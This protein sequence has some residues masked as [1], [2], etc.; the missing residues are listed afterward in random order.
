MIRWQ[1]NPLTRMAEQAGRIGPASSAERIAPV[2]STAE[3]VQ[4]REAINAM[5]DRMADSLER[6]H[7][8]ASTAAHELRTP[9]AQ[10]RTTIEVALRRD[11][12][13]DE[14]R[15]ALTEILTDVERLQ[16]LIHGLLQLARGAEHAPV[17][18]GRPVPLAALIRDAAREHQGVI[19]ANGPVRDDLAVV[20][21]ESLLLAALGNVLENAAHHA[22][23]GPAFLRVENAGTSVR[24][25]VAD[26]GPGVPETERERI[27]QPLTRLA[28]PR[29][30][31]A[32][33]AEASEG[34]GLGLTVARATAR[35]YGGDL[36]CRD[37]VDGAP[38]AEFVFSFHKPH[39]AA[40]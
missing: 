5:I 35:A 12:D 13:A 8:F 16:K 14:Y 27:F 3:Y 31:P 40:T 33:E 18:P 24:L 39:E 34:F 17:A 21:D 28:R 22:P 19:L 15:A 9:L 7:R 1:L 25:I 6:E 30:T 23:G 32:C 2:G 38:G 29:A 4:L 11:R 36:T 37:R 10:L 26:R 20:G